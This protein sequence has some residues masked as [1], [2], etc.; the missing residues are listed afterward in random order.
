M[1][2]RVTMTGGT[3]SGNTATRS[4]GGVGV[5]RSAAFTQRGGTISGN[6]APSSTP[7]YTH[8]LYRMPN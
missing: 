2:G 5:F 1:E 6:R 4:V 3:V 7:A 8:N